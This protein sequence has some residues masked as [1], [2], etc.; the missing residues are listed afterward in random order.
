MSGPLDGRVAV[1][2]GAG[3]GIGRGIADLFASQGA[4]VVVND[5]GCTEEGAGEDV[6]VADQV[7]REIRERGGT[8]AANADTVATREGAEAIVETAIREFGRLDILV[9]VAGIL[10]ERMIF[11]MTEDEWDDV[12]SV[13]LK[14]TIHCATAAMPHL[15]ASPSG[16]L[17]TFTS[18]A[19]LLGSAGQPNYSAAKD[20]IVTYTRSVALAA[21]GSGLTS[22]C[23]SPSGDS[24]LNA[25]VP[26]DRKK[27][28]PAEVPASVS[29]RPPE[30]VAPMVAYLAGPS[31][32]GVNGQT[33]LVTGGHV[34]L[35]RQPRPLKSMH[36]REGWTAESVGQFL[37]WV[38]LRPNAE[39]VSA[40]PTRDFS[41]W[42][43]PVAGE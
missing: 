7:V 25:R 34:Q 36:R 42:E 14:G 35:I 32:G 11:N 29:A 10:R 38:L 13:H 2:T 27:D 1:V 31:S 43:P 24:R 4:A 19:G 40:T 22:N 30:A 15:Q 8:A 23:I 3:R 33:F 17:I 20:G 16:R 12:V 37:P 5:L 21:G 18:T 41:F 26:A 28:K 9:T 39:T 6:L